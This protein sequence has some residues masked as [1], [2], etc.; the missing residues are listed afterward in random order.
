[1]EPVQHKHISNL[2]SDPKSLLKQ[3]QQ[4]PPLHINNIIFR[5]I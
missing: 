2:N 5:A 3:L 4:Y 1:M